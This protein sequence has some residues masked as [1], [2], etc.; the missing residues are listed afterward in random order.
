MKSLITTLLLAITLSSTAFGD[1]LEKDN[2]PRINSYF[3]KCEL[4][5]DKSDYNRW[6]IFNVKSEFFGLRTKLTLFDFWEG[7]FSNVSKTVFTK[8]GTAPFKSILNKDFDTMQ[9]RNSSG[10]E[11]FAFFNETKRAVHRTLGSRNNYNN[12][13]WFNEI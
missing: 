11:E 7:S 12:C 4:D 13:F 3:V 1:A 6:I 10:D 5:L 9:F 8:Y 2:L